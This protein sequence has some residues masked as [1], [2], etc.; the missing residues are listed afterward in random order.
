M[1]L[2]ATQKLEFKRNGFVTIRNAVDQDLC[3]KARQVVWDALPVNKDDP[4]SWKGRNLGS[5]IPDIDSTDPFEEFAR[6]AFPHAEALVGK[7]HLAPPDDPP[8]EVSHHA[9]TLVGADH[10]G[11]LSPHISY[12]RED[13]D[14]DW[15]ERAS[16]N[17]NA[18]V[19]GYAPDD[20]FG[21]NI[22]YIPLTIGVAI[23]FDTVQP[24]GGGFTVWPGS[25]IRLA[26]YFE[27]HTYNEYVKDQDVLS[28][29]ELGVPFEIS[30]ESGDMVL[31]HH[32]LVH[33]AGPN[34]SGHIRMA[35]IGR[36]VIDDI[37]NR[38]DE[39]FQEKGHGLGDLW[40]QYPTLQ[41]T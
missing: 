40:K 34:I 11:M 12:P 2:S 9:G 36:F 4:E 22:N 16:E 39:D 7:G 17:Q 26:E 27:S 31:W 20:R 41:D 37:L 15:T 29:L 23:Y 32:N 35:S 5:D 19:D 3:Q 21:E 1:T 25:H 6:I 38:M 30:G 10:D 18:H 33:A 28:E 14:S 13:E 8:V 24:G